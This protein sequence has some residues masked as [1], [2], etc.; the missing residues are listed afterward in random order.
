MSMK[1]IGLALVAASSASS[2]WADEPQNPWAC[3]PLQREPASQQEQVSVLEQC[4]RQ[5]NTAAM[6]VLA[7]RMPDKQNARIWL[8]RAAELDHAES[9]YQLGLEEKDP[10]LAA[11]YMKAAAHALKH[12][13]VAQ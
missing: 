8:L 7:N 5:G 13:H 11:Q 6:F 9:L 12:R 1:L 4:A 3:A 10:R 2:A